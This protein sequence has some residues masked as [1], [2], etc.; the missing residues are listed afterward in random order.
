M[1]TGGVERTSIKRSWGVWRC[2]VQHE[3]GR[4]GAVAGELRSGSLNQ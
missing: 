3:A 4:P 1:E 2:G